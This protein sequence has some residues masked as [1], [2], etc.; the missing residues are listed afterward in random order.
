MTNFANDSADKQ[1]PNLPVQVSYANTLESEPPYKGTILDFWWDKP[2]INIGLLCSNYGL[3][4]YEHLDMYRTY[5]DT[6]TPSH[7]SKEARMRASLLYIWKEI[8]TNPATK[9]RDLQEEWY[10]WDPRL[11]IQHRGQ[12]AR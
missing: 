3:P 6:E 12:P 10:L 5:F 7:E 8:Y 9:E 1:N 2:E 4:F 11:I